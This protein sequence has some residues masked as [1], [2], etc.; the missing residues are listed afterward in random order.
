MFSLCKVQRGQRHVKNERL[1]NTRWLMLYQY[2]QNVMLKNHTANMRNTYLNLFPFQ[3]HSF[4]LM[5]T[6]FI[7]L[8]ILF[9]KPVKQIRDDVQGR[10]KRD[11]NNIDNKI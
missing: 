5:Q 10:N 7:Y 4:K 2:S 11:T 3:K 1:Y 9:I 8:F 6:L